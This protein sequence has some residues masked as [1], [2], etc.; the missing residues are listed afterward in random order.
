MFGS[1]EPEIQGIEPGAEIVDDIPGGGD[2]SGA[3]SD[4]AVAAFGGGSVNRAGDGEDRS[5][6]LERLVSSDE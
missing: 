1:G 2:E 6:L 4:E 5:T 3:L